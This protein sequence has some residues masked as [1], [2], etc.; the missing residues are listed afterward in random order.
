MASADSTHPAPG[1]NYGLRRSLPSPS[2]W[3]ALILGLVLVV[4]YRWLID[5]AFVYF[6]YVDNLLF[7]GRG[8]VYNLGEYVEGFSSPLWTI[9][10]IPLRAT[11]VGYWELVLGLGI[12]SWTLFWA[13]GVAVNRALC[14][15]G[16]RPFSLPLLFLSANYAVTTWFTSGL[17]QPFIQLAAAAFAWLVVRP[18]ARLPRVLVAFAPLVRPELVLPFV[19][20]FFWVWGR[21]RRIPWLF[22]SLAVAIQLAWMAFRI[23]YYAD[24]FPNTFHLKDGVYWEQGLA[25]L[26]DAFLPYGVPY[27]AALLLGVGLCLDLA[28]RANGPLFWAER[29]VMLL[30]ALPGILYV[31]KIG[32]TH[33]HYMYLAFPFCLVLF[34]LSGIAEHVVGRLRSVAAVPLAVLI[35]AAAGLGYP[36]QQPQHPFWLESSGTKVEHVI[37]DANLARHHRDLSYKKRRA[38]VPLAEL[39]ELEERYE[40]G[41]VPHEEIAVHSWCASMYRAVLYSTINRHGLTD[42]ILARIQCEPT[43]PGHYPLRPFALD[44][45]AVQQ[46]ASVIGQGMYREA[47]E[48]G[49]APEW[50]VA[51]LDRLEWLE[52]KIYNHHDFL[53]NLSLALRFEPK[54]DPE[55]L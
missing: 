42:G 30:A 38:E 43:R 12:L 17:E 27:V 13:I 23:T 20:G 31:T 35:A 8:L 36:S 53:E 9:V 25:Y 11:Q 19:V 50:I 47:V 1:G 37:A 51:H 26:A 32:G 3:L 55:E 21:T 7:L 28:Q 34:A 45:Q 54:I 16:A 18:N 22:G 10:L 24:L 6:R 48:A 41:P 40:G 15:P 46:A 14:P 5:D 49:R 39:L 2:E 33:L 44:I 29:G 52:A 4:R